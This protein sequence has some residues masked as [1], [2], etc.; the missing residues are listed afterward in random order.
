MPLSKCSA[1]MKVKCTDPHCLVLESDCKL[2]LW[3]GTLYYLK[4]F[5]MHL[6]IPSLFPHPTE[7][8]LSRRLRDY[9]AHFTGEGVGPAYFAQVLEL[10]R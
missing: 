4:Y 6:V 5:H 7:A 2:L 8:C 9:D 3:K 10:F 1:I